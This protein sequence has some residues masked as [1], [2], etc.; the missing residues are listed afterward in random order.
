[1]LHSNLII[2]ISNWKKIPKMCTG[3]LTAFCYEQLFFISRKVGTQIGKL[4]TANRVLTQSCSRINDVNHV[5]FSSYVDFIH[6]NVLGNTW[7]DVKA[8]KTARFAS[9]WDCHWHIYCSIM[10][11]ELQYIVCWFPFTS[12]REIYLLTVVCHLGP[13]PAYLLV[14]LAEDPAFHQSKLKMDISVFAASGN[15]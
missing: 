5:P 13:R 6:T 7:R 3:S 12:R 1:M 4:Q 11:S 14:R 9:D 2:V 8:N 10:Y 15:D